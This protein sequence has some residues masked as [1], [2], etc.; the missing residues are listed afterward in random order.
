MAAS[1]EK[2]IITTTFPDN[3]R[4]SHPEGFFKVAALKYLRKFARKHPWFTVFISKIKKNILPWMFF[5]TFSRIFQGYYFV[6][7]LQAA[8]SLMCKVSWLNDT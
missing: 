6:E 3:L 2:K 5:G 7:H 4:S 1:V 8:I